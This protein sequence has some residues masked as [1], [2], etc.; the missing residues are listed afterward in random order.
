MIMKQFEI[1]KLPQ[2]VISEDD[3]DERFVYIEGNVIPKGANPPE[4]FDERNFIL[5]PSFKNLL[6]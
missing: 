5:T 6:R 2:L 3:R 1:R 4:Q